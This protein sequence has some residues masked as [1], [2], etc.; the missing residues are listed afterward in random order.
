MKDIG[1]IL[2]IVCFVF[3]FSCSKDKTVSP[4]IALSD[5]PLIKLYTVSPTSVTQFVDSIVFVITCWDKDG[6]IGFDNAD[7]MALWLTDNRFPITEKYHIPPLT[8]DSAEIAIQT[9]LSVVLDHT[10]L[11]D[12]TQTSEIATF[13]IKLRDRAGHW[14][15]TVT[16]GNITI[17][18]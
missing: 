15:N 14:S 16:T 8:P 6:D 10:I 9:Q 3:I 11:K 2:M 5:T 4:L 12:T 18:K 17:L 7:S 13:S 1:K